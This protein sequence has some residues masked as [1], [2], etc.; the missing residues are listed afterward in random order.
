MYFTLRYF[1]C[2]NALF[3]SYLFIILFNFCHNLVGMTNFNK[4]F[5]NNNIKIILFSFRSDKWAAVLGKPWV[6]KT[7]VTNR[8]TKFRICSNHFLD[9][10][11]MTENRQ[12][13]KPTAIPKLGTFF[14]FLCMDCKIYYFIIFL[15]WIMEVFHMCVYVIVVWLICF[16]FLNFRYLCFIFEHFH[17]KG[18]AKQEYE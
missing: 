9:S 1:V 14:L 3:N 15:L 13:L 10:D 18:E 4:S 17:I 7:A 12:R 8:T 11:Y 6:T 5:A 2:V 16:P